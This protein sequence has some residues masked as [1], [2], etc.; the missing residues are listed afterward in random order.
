MAKEISLPSY[1]YRK[2]IFDALEELDWVLFPIHGNKYFAGYQPFK[3]KDAKADPVFVFPIV[4]IWE[5]NDE[6][7]RFIICTHVISSDKCFVAYFDNI[8][9]NNRKRKVLI[10]RNA[11]EYIEQIQSKRNEK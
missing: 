2:K 9:E 3:K 6:V 10:I 5:K 7:Y 11:N 1:K 4:P 8:I